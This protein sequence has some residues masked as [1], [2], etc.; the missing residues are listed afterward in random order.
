M[1][2]AAVADASA[3]ADTEGLVRPPQQ[4]RSRRTL[5]RMLDAARELLGDRGPEG[6]TVTGI[7]RRARTSVGSFYARFDGKDDLLRYLGESS[8]E[9]T[10]AE[11]DDLLETLSGGR[12]LRQRLEPA[13]RR[14]FETFVEG[15]GRVVLLLDGIHD[16]LPS[17]RSRLEDR[18][19]T[20]LTDLLSGPPERRELAARFLLASLRDA[21]L[22]EGDDSAESPFGSRERV[23]AELVEMVVG[24]LGGQVRRPEPAIAPR[25]EPRPRPEPREAPREE[26]AASA[27]PESA[28][29]SAD[30]SAESSDEP[31]PAPEPEPGSEMDPFDVWQ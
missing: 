19:A 30:D 15:P 16:P 14:L 8:L 5:E 12:D 21:A 22:R 29:G 31:A 27:K 24:Y 4:D 20:G 2:D 10:V 7:T 1:T 28:D 3:G 26:A 25:S 17:R 23:I 6:L 13:A 18:A 9:G 11:V